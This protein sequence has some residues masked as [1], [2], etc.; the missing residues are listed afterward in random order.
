MTE[1]NRS[2]SRPD[3]GTVDIAGSNSDNHT[4]IQLRDEETLS[5][6]ELTIHYDAS[7]GNE[8]V[9]ELYDN[10]SST[11]SGNEDDR[12]YKAHISPGD[13]LNPDMVFRDIENDLLVTTSGN[14]NAEITVNAGGYKITG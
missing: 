3:T 7:G 10:D 4:L 11:N 8:A 1:D 5:L 12:V 6:K 9:V 14:Q 2:S 13:D